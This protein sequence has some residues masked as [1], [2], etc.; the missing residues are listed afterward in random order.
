M[1]LRP[2]DRA[3][4]FGGS[5]KL[6]APNNGVFNPAFGTDL[7][8]VFWFSIDTLPG[9]G[10]NYEMVNTAVGDVTKDGWFCFLNGTTN[11]FSI[12]SS[13][14]TAYGTLGF[15]AQAIVA[16]KWYMAACSWDNHSGTGAYIITLYDT[17]GLINSNSTGAPG[18]INTANPQP[19]NIGGHGNPAFA[20]VHGRIDK[21]GIWKRTAIQGSPSANT[22]WNSGVGLQGSQV[23]ADPNLPIGL[24]A[25]YDLN[26]A[27]G[28]GIWRDITGAH[29]M[30]ATGTVVSV[31]PS[32]Q[33]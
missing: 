17:A 31:P 10:V 33:F 3:A 28:S 5:S 12:G 22:L 13:T 27:T 21:L 9:A 19:L 1:P 4:D 30:N 32:G 16:N 15:S 24:T 18:F 26:E 14:G 20:W 8:V 7:Y 23:L 2:R 29:D 25:W 11:F 6:S